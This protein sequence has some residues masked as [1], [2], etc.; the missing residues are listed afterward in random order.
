MGVSVSKLTSEM[1]IARPVVKPLVVLAAKF[2]GPGP[3]RLKMVKLAH[4]LD[5]PP[6]RHEAA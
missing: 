1:A 4:Q 5:D 2:L 3:L 6:M